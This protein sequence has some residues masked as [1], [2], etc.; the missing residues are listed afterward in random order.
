M[1]IDRG[2]L[3]RVV[4]LEQLHYGPSECPH[5]ST[6]QSC[7]ACGELEGVEGL[8][9]KAVDQ[10]RTLLDYHQK[11]KRKINH[12]HCLIL[13]TI[14][15]E[16]MFTIFE[17]CTIPRC[18]TDGR[19]DMRTPLK[20]GAICQ[21]WRHIAWSTPNLWT[22]I[23]IHLDFEKIAQH[24]DQNELIQ[25]QAW[26]SRSKSLLLSIYISHGKKSGPKTGNDMQMWHLILEA[27][28]RCSH[29]WRGINLDIS[30]KSFE[31]LSGLIQGTP[32]LESLLIKRQNMSRYPSA[33]LFRNVPPK[34]QCVMMDNFSIKYVNINPNTVTVLQV[35]NYC[36]D[37]PLELIKS[38]PNLESFHMSRTHF[39]EQWEPPI[40]THHK[41]VDLS[42]YI[43]S[44]E[45]TFFSAVTLPNL[46]SL[47][48]E[49]HA[50]WASEVSNSDLIAFFHRSRCPLTYLA[51]QQL[52]FSNDSLDILLRAVPTL[53]HLKL[54]LVE[55]I[56][57]LNSTDNQDI[58][59]LLN[60]LRETNSWPRDS[61]R[62]N[63][64]LFLPSLSSLIYVINDPTVYRSFQWRYLEELFT[65]LQDPVLEN[66]HQRPLKKFRMAIDF[67]GYDLAIEELYLSQENLNI[68]L[69]LQRKGVDISCMCG[70][71]DVIWESKR[72][73]GGL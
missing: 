18:R 50:D 10:L 37:N 56:S 5:S 69:N 25:L 8:I 21:E 35:A 2:R 38:S 24:P 12:A 71:T 49:R 11:L 46:Q 52:E 61:D 63:D 36:G 67:T 51:I 73:T 40:Y 7:S 55:R 13:K 31:Y 33:P 66:Y 23:S 28:A 1:R 58:Y 19:P 32:Q 34:L 64:S 9:Q 72:N 60:C 6:T 27:I 4:D 68:L 59:H 47:S 62:K 39:S 20:L 41:L 29:R 65:P 43:T 44:N 22:Y 26:I 42:I 53:A 14:P 17:L 3:G 48:L 70:D 16:I 57:Y 54:G 15:P 45:S 30:T